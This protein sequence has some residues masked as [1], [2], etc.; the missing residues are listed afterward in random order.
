MLRFDSA[1]FLFLILFI[2]SFSTLLLSG[3]RYGFTSGDSMTPTWGEHN[4]IWGYIPK[5]LADVHVGDV[6]AFSFNDY[7][8]V[9]R[10]TD[11]Y[12]DAWIFARGDNPDCGNGQMLNFSAIEFVVSGHIGF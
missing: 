2:L 10:V 4:L 7:R 8:M 1:F 12:G 9:H 3:A 11:I 6:I 5:N